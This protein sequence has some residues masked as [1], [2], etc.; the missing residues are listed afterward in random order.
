MTDF[1]LGDSWRMRNPSSRE[2]SYFSPLHQSSS[3]IDYFLVSKSF[4][5]HIQENRIHP[6]IISDHAPVSLS[7]KL[8]LNIRSPTRWRFNTSLLQDPHFTPLIKR[9]WASFLEMNDS[10]EISPSLLWETGKTVL[11]GIIISYASYKKKT[12]AGTG[13][14]IR[15]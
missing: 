10:P 11:T 7:I 9:E 13:K 1:G 6:I 14:K 12:A 2:Y 15:D 3:R 4:T 8:N 5:Q